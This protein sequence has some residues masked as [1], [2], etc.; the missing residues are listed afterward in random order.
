MPSLPDI[1]SWLDKADGIIDHGLKIVDKLDSKL[2]RLMTPVN[3]P[4]KPPE[5]TPAPARVEPAASKTATVS[6]VSLD[7]G[8]S[9]ESTLG[10]QLDTILDDLAHLET[11]HLPAQGKIDGKPCDCIAKAA[12]SLRRHALETIPIATRQGQSA[13][14]FAQLSTWAQHVMSI[15]TKDQ[16][17]TGKYDT[18]FLN[19]AGEAS[20]FRKSLESQA[21]A[22]GAKPT[23][24]EPCE[25]ARQK[26]KKYLAEMPPDERAQIQAK[27]MARLNTM[28]EKKEEVHA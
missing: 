3:T 15:G 8:V 5:P 20:N 19:L 17:G 11:E 2:D 10:Y 28:A 24:C 12:R 22:M 16:V 4:P 25:A 26:L 23:T 7:E 27:V 21:S 13:D 14:T 9:D 18:E 1:F 6:E